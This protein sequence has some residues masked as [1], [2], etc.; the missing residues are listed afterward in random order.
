MGVKYNFLLSLSQRWREVAAVFDCNPAAF[1]KLL[2]K[3]T[4]RDAAVNVEMLSVKSMLEAV[5]GKVPAELRERYREATVTEWCAMVNSLRDGL[6]TLA[7]FLERTTPPLTAYAKKMS[8]GTLKGNIEE[9]MLWTLRESFGLQSL[10]NAHYLTVY[11]YMVARKSVYNEARVAYNRE[12]DMA[13]RLAAA[14]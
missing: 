8:G 2:S 13:S 3:I 10:E 1:E 9:A 7:D 12:M 14:R 5:G 6:A 4:K 11:E